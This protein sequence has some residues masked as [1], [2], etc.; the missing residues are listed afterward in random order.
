MNEKHSILIVD[1]NPDNIRVLGT[2]LRQNNYRVLISQ[3]GLQ[4]LKTLEMT[5]VD[6]ILLDIMMPGL[7]GFETCSRIKANPDWEIIPVIFLTAKVEEA[8]VV[9]GLEMGAVDYIT[10]PFN[11]QVLL[12]RVK[13]HLQLHQYHKLLLNQAYMDGLTQIPNRLEFE[14]VL[15]TEW[16]RALRLN[17]HLAVLM[18]DIDYF[19][20]LNDSYG[21]LIGDE[22]LKQVAHAIH[23]EAKR[24]GD[25]VARYGGEEF[26]AILPNTE[27]SAALVLAENMR[28][29]VESLNIDN[30]QTKLGKITISLGVSALI[31]NVDLAAM[32][33]VDKA[34]RQLFLAKNTGRNRVCVGN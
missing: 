4:A 29:A 28:Q 21:H 18:I 3:S 22:V 7:D 30:K 33:L 23:S 13:T 8:E 20:V 27:L 16:N 12:A 15:Q 25:L 2:V 6:L 31:P 17:N 11:S 26:V 9:K 24:A 5:T 34:D 10:K 14:K 19:K 32:Q 1:D